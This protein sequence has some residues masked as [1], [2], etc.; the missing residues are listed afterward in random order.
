MLKVLSFLIVSGFFFVSATEIS[1]QKKD[2]IPDFYQYNF[3]K[4]DFNQVQAVVYVNVK[5]R[6]LVDQIGEGG[7]EQNTGKGYCLYRLKAEVKEVFKG[8]IVKENF[9]FYTI[10][11][12]DY[13][14]KDSLLGEKVVFLNWSDNYPDKKMSLGTI[15]NSTRSIEHNILKNMRKIAKKK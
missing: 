12:A 8:K 6:E 13:R 1:G 5:S 15:E 14:N 4:S 10:V 11:D 9:E 7:C 3:L 2:E